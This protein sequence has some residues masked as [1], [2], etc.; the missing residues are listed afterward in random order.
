MVVKG[1]DNQNE[2]DQPPLLANHLSEEE[3]SP[4]PMMFSYVSKTFL[5]KKKISLKVASR[6][7]GD[8]QWSDHLRTDNS[9]ETL[10]TLSSYTPCSST[11]PRPGPSSTASRSCIALHCSLPVVL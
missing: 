10:V 7:S 8:I 2:M 5:G 9:S 4:P 3:G 6:E 11:T 1:H